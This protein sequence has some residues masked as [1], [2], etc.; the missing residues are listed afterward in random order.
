[1]YPNEDTISNH[2]RVI[3]VSNNTALCLIKFLDT[4]DYFKH[5]D[6]EI[7]F[8]TRTF[9]KASSMRKQKKKRLQ[10]VYL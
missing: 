3:I 7:S 2:F 1:M 9:T 6:A 10:Y 5:S 4:S 8:F